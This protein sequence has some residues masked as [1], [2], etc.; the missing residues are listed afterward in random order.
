MNLTIQS[1][2]S[3]LNDLTQFR[4]LTSLLPLVVILA[5]A[6]LADRVLAA[7]NNLGFTVASAAKVELP[8]LEGIDPENVI[9]RRQQDECVGAVE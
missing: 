5:A 3:C 1:A 9:H 7:G 4:T 8:K 2:K 6:L